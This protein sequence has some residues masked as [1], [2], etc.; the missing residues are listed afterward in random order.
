VR[1]ILDAAMF[2]VRFICSGQDNIS[3]K[4]ESRG[5]VET[6]IQSRQCVCVCVCVC[7]YVCV[8]VCV[9]V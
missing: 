9:C 1:I 3:D 8:C 5:E 6:T 7:V 2:R 4:K